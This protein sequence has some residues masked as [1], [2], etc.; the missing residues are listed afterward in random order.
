MLQQAIQHVLNVVNDPLLWTFVQLGCIAI[1]KP[2]GI[3]IAKKYLRN[4]F[5]NNKDGA[6]FAIARNGKIE[7]Q[8]GFFEFDVF[9]KAFKDLQKFPA[10]IHF[11]IA[12]HGEVNKENCHPFSVCKE[13]YAVVHNGVLPIEPPKGR[14]ESDTAYFANTILEDILP[15]IKYGN[16]GFTKL[17]EEAVGSYNKIVLLRADGKPWLFNESEGYWFKGSWFSNSGYRYTWTGSYHGC[18]YQSTSDMWKGLASGNTKSKYC[19]DTN[20]W[21][22]VPVDEEDIT[23]RDDFPTEYG[24]EFVPKTVQEERVAAWLAERTKKSSRIIDARDYMKERVNK[25]IHPVKQ[26]TKY[27][28]DCNKIVYTTMNDL[29]EIETAYSPKGTVIYVRHYSAKTHAGNPTLKDQAEKP[30]TESANITGTTPNLALQLE[31]QIPSC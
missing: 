8:K 18:G 10:L 20:S 29:S 2:K 16:D 19:A 5:N 4:S 7:I 26:V 27:D 25:K 13:R 24:D 3:Q 1:W 28:S 21:E 14:K 22:E 15:D 30:K 12:T 23:R 11:R 9:W 17:C 6:G 31:N